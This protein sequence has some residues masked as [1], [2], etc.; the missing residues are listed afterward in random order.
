MEHTGVTYMDRTGT[1][2]Y[3]KKDANTGR[4]KL[5]NMTF[6][7]AYGVAEHSEHD[8]VLNFK[9]ETTIR[10]E[11]GYTTYENGLPVHSQELNYNFTIQLL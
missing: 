5:H 4:L 3:V 10:A 6:D 1:W 7:N 8:Y 9:S 11:G 2:E